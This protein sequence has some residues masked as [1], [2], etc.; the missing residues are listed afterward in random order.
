MLK[1]KIHYINFLLLIFSCDSMY[2]SKASHED[3]KYIVFENC[4]LELFETCP[5]C[6]RASNIQPR[7]NGTFLAIDQLCPHCEYFRRWKSQPC[8]G[9]TPVGNLHL[10]ASLYFSGA[11]FFQ[12]KKVCGV[13]FFF[14]FKIV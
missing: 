8:V 2:T 11:S 12:M 1:K 5:V 3:T 14:L 4:L 10:S 9:S 13:Y 7:S 6:S